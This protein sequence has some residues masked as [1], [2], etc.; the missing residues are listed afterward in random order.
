MIAAA[1][2]LT[3]PKGRNDSRL[4]DTSVQGEDACTNII[5]KAQENI[6]TILKDNM[7]SILDALKHPVWPA[8]G[9]ACFHS[10]SSTTLMTMSVVMYSPFWSGILNAS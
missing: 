7:R 5:N 6:V 8:S 4:C 1:M 10:I 9:L 3:S 2:A